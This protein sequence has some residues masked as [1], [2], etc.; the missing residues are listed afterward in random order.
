M[1]GNESGRDVLSD[2]ELSQEYYDSGMWGD[3]H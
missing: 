2:L 3:W 1:I